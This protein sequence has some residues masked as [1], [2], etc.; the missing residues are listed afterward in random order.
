MID[1]RGLTR[2]AVAAIGGKALTK[3]GHVRVLSCCAKPYVRFCAWEI[4]RTA[5]VGR[6]IERQSFKS[7]RQKR[8]KGLEPSTSSLGS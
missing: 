8:A 5:D 2:G 7:L 3:F 1:E 4:R 6:S